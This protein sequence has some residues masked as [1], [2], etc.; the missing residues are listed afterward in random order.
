MLLMPT[1]LVQLQLQLGLLHCLLPL[2]MPL[3]LLMRVK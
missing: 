2:M 3:E 1:V